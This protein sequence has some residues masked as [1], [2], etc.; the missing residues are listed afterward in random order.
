M[1]FLIT[2]HSPMIF[3]SMAHKSCKNADKFFQIFS[4]WG[5][6]PDDLSLCISTVVELSSEVKMQTLQWYF[7]WFFALADLRR[8]GALGTSVPAL[9]PISF[10]FLQFWGKISPNRLA[11]P[12]WALLPPPR[13]GNPGSATGLQVRVWSF[14]GDLLLNQSFLWSLPAL[15]FLGR[16]SPTRPFEGGGL[17]LPIM[18]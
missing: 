10:I 13:L 1:P 14:G 18:I 3:F 5:G 2:S 17:P 6:N 11:L 8:D 7:L 12:P 16:G 9:G 15:F 4:L